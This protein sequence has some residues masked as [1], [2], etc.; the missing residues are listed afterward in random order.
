M[1]TIEKNVVPYLDGSIN[2]HFDEKSAQFCDAIDSNERDLNILEI[3]PG[4]GA[5]LMG[6][7][8][9][10]LSRVGR[11]LAGI[12]F[13]VLELFPSS[14]ATLRHAADQLVEQGASFNF[15]IGDAVDLPFKDES[16]DIVNC[17][18]V[19]HEVYS[20]GGGKPALKK[21]LGEL[22]R[23]T[24][25]GGLLLYRDVYP[26][27]TS[28][29]TPIEQEYDKPSWVEF[30]R[31]FLPHYLKNSNHPYNDDSIS[32]NEHSGSIYG[33][34]P[35]GLAREIQRHYITFRDH[36]IRSGL[37]GV[38]VDA[39][40][41]DDTEWVRSERGFEKKI[42][43]MPHSTIEAH[44][45]PVNEDR[46]GMFAAASDFDVYID[47]QLQSLFRAIKNKMPDAVQVFEDWL[48]REGTESY[49]Y[50]SSSE[51]IDLIRTAG[52]PDDGVEKFRIQN[53]VD[54]K[55]AE[56]DYYTGYLMS[57]LGKYALPDKKIIATFK[58]V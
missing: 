35:A 29:H 27:D 11:G 43:L 54:Y 58:K 18:A 52:R 10:K 13:T 17:S 24:K 47:V 36:A 33:H 6:L 31:R 37:L 21:A 53:A 41:Y 19:L 28:I 15:V 39:G 48:S 49:I 44:N 8:E 50:G 7:A 3:G 42:Y 26:C 25:P 46:T 2:L 4:G 20:Y 14:S 55:V 16:L 51:V 57:A 9:K 12:S 1:L 56:R 22:E 40:R 30:V 23:V 38:R 34:A 32:L 5:A 45:L